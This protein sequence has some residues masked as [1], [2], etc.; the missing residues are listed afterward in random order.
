M[1]TH[2]HCR[3]LLFQHTA[4]RRRL[5]VWGQK[6]HRG[7]ECFNTQPHEG[8]C[9]VECLMRRVLEE[10]QHTAARRRLLN[11]AEAPS[12]AMMFQHTAARRRLRQVVILPYHSF[13]FQHTAA[14]RR[15]LTVCK[16]RAPMFSVFQHTAAR[17]RLPDGSE[18]LVNSH[19]VST[20]SRTKAAATGNCAA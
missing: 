9:E 14:R 17:R 12:C 13:L 5:R 2:Q 8:G 10:F 18:G 4:A 1:I 16:R 3:F 11:Q 15:L 6:L 7:F 20:H 19:I